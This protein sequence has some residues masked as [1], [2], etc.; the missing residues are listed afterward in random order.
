MGGRPDADGIRA[1]SPN[2]RDPLHALLTL[3][4]HVLPRNRPS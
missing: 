1:A 3:E 4:E 2:G